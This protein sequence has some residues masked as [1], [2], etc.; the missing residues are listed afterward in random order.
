[1]K[2]EKICQVAIVGAGYMA[3]EHIRAFQDIPG[4]NISGIHSRTRVRAE[5]IAAQF[6]IVKVCGSIE[7]LYHLTE[8]DLVVVTVPELEMNGVSRACFKY[9]GWRCWK[10]QPDTTMPTPGK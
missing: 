9:P 8:A 7:E 4:V 6:G 10:S 3:G 1:M 5:Q 2:V